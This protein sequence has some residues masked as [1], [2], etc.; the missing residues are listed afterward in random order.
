[1][2]ASFLSLQW[3]G[4]VYSLVLLVL[5]LAA[6]LRRQESGFLFLLAANALSFCLSLLVQFYPAQVPRF[7]ILTAAY[8]PMALTLT[9]WILLA[10]VKPASNGKSRSR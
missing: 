6:Y 4:W 10:A 3:L 8:L 5:M 9:G 7:A 1:M 2:H